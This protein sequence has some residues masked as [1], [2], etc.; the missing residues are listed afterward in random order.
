MNIPLNILVE[1]KECFGLMRE[2]EGDKRPLSID[3]FRRCLYS[4][5]VFETLV[6]AI[7]GE[8][9]VEVETA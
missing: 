8:Y 5:T 9:Q 4:F 1:A 2:A 3:E 7:A 6:N